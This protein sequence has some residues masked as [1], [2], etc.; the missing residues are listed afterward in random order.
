[1]WFGLAFFVFSAALYLKIFALGLL[2]FCVLAA[3]WNK[4]GAGVFA[5]A[6]SF[7]SAITLTNPPYTEI[8]FF[9]TYAGIG[10]LV[11]FL[12]DWKAGALLCLVS[13][14]GSA[15]VFG[16]VDQF[17]RDIAGE[18]AF[19][20]ALLASVILGPSNG[21]AVRSLGAAFGGGNRANHSH[22]VGIPRT[23]KMVGKANVNKG[24][25]I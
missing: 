16:Y 23:G 5:L 7:A 8:W 12:Y 17:Q 2:S 25:I 18:I 21:I 11:F 3:R 20:A 24:P 14:P 13:L 6:L 15:L 9:A 19:G 4:K 1:M 10:A 22:A